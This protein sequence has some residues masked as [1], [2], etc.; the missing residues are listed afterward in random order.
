[1]KR[2]NLRPFKLW[3]LLPIGIVFVLVLVFRMLNINTSIW[4]NLLLPI[5]NSLFQGVIFLAGAFICYRVFLANGSRGIVLI[6]GGFLSIG[7]TAPLAGW[8]AVVAGQNVNITVYNLGVLLASGFFVTSGV[9]MFNG[10]STSPASR[11]KPILVL[12]YCAVAVFLAAIAVLSSLGRTPTFFVPGSGPTILR[13]IILGTATGLLMISTF[14]F[15]WLYARSKADLMYWCALGL[16]MTVVGL[17]AILLYTTFGDPMNWLGRLAQY[18][19]SLYFLAAA[20]VVR[21]EAQTKQI[22]VPELLRH[23]SERSRTN[24]ELLV[25]TANDAI[26]SLDSDGRIIV[27][28]PAAERMFGYDQVEALGSYLSNLLL[29]VESASFFKN[30]FDRLTHED[31]WEIKRDIPELR[32]RRKNGEDFPARMSYS[33]EKTPQGL[34]TVVVITDIT[35]RRKAEEQLKQRTLELEAANKEL[36]AF[37]YSVS[38]DLRAPLRSID[39]FSQA[40]LEDYLDKLDEPGKDYL[41]RVRSAAQRMGVLIDDLLSLSRVTRSDMRSEAVDL[42]ALAQSIAEELRETQPERRVTFIIAPG[43]TASGDVRLLRVL[44]ENLLSNAWKFTG[45]HPQARIEFGVTQVSG[46]ETFFVRD[47]GAG[48]DMTYVDNLFGVFQRL[49]SQDE[50]PGT[51]IGLATV[52]RIIHRHGGQVWAKGAVE[53]GATLYFTLNQA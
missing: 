23:Y 37:T 31:V 44:M 45:H 18:L 11:R 13:Q 4:P 27:W 10:V 19:G 24:Y 41:Q 42:S 22:E 3:A 40:L 6:G 16:G 50:F 51:G 30:E 7:I 32:V 52:Q 47:D 53:E 8:L 1:M 46:K 48:F 49:H 34:T 29:P 26:I 2:M 21:Q 36:E 28:N 33:A 43:L 15:I 39:G 12:T 38:H 20:I 17:T 14:L 5:L 25:G 9:Y 35:E